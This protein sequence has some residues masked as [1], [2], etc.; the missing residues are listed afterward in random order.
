MSKKVFIGLGLFLMF[1]VV[2]A[3]LV[4]E[5]KGSEKKAENMNLLI[6]TI[7]TMR[8]DR[9]GAYGYEK[10]ETPNVDYLAQ[11][12]VMFENCYT[13]VPLTLPSHCS[14][15]TGRYPIGHRVRNNGTFFLN[16][17][18]V[19]L[20]EKMKERGYNTYAVIASFVLLSKFGLN[21]GFFEY[22]DSLNID[23]L[24][25]NFYS[26][27]TADVVYSKFSRWF[28]N[29][30]SQ[31]FFAWVHFFDP[32][33]PYTP[34]QKYR[35]ENKD[36][37]SDLYDGEVAY[38][39]VFIGKIIE[40]LK[41][42]NVL[43]QTLVIITGDHGE[44]FGEHLEYGHSVF[45]YEE[46][47]KVPLIV[48][49]PSLFPESLLVKNRVN[50]IDIMP[51]ILELYGLDVPS[52]IQG[53]SLIRLLDGQGEKGARSFYIESMY[54]KEEMGWAPLT[55]IIDGNYKYISLPEAELYD[56]KNDRRERNNLFWKNNKV[57]KEK[58]NALRGFVLEY[59]SSD[60]DP[61]R[62]LSRE[63]I[64]HLESL[65]YISSFSS[66][67]ERP[68]D[69]KEGILLQAQFNLIN[70]EIEKGN[71]DFAEE[72]LRRVAAQDPDKKMPQ[73]Y[74][75][76]AKVYEMKPD[77]LSVVNTW[78]ESVEAF[79]ENNQFKIALA[80][81]LFQA[82]RI[83]EA[84]K[85]GVEI[86]KD[87][88]KYTRAYI[89]LGSIDEKR[90]RVKNGLEHF[91]KA[92]SLEPNNVLLNIRYARMLIKDNDHEHAMQICQKI[93]DDD[94]ITNSSKNAD[95]VSKI[96][97]MLTEMNRNDQALQ[98]LLNASTMDDAGVETWNYLGV[99]Y[100][101]KKEYAKALEAYQKAFDLD[102]KFALVHNNLGTLYLR[103][104][105]EKKNSEMMAKAIDS[106][107][108]AIKNDPRLA[109]AYNGRA[110]A[111]KFSNQVGHALRDWKRA[112]EINPDFIDA[113]FNLGITY[114]QVGNKAEAL[115]I[116]NQCEE[117]FFD[118]LSLRDQSRLK[119]LIDEAR[120]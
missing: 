110:S 53:K 70:D 3:L 35:K 28:R 6:I 73:Y 52:E 36:S 81:K 15:F 72:E 46:N 75:L 85:L 56:L 31:K 101:R 78:R 1:A 120:L 87:D 18:E 109:S 114:L 38:T 71:L 50:L 64:K 21:Q 60:G 74:E 30:G 9:I 47:L 42:E 37:F 89:L 103:M 16:E 44:A 96:G 40:D 26:E 115:K 107:D 79:P 94:S 80:F 93:L 77:P 63:D 65:G 45:C 54:G 57:A 2:I 82:E 66:K 86:V 41:S 67:T 92:L 48:F 7:D 95:I 119:N 34:P 4:I 62:E 20:A 59:S 39:D 55:G 49:N 32:H 19:T 76:L 29:R 33:A 5:R 27:I 58:D 102:P 116:L 106:F 23:E 99:V 43:D 105:L 8:A 117:K 118:R 24:L 51:T 61:R 17:D 69:P 10:A 11:R 108:L 100:Y 84:E 68:L 112:L 12:G 91:A 104:F 83:E 111:F 14:I 97:I 22:D 88:D 25:H 113:Y 90:G 98:V 13:S